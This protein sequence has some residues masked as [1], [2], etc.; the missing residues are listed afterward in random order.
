MNFFSE[1]KDTQPRRM[2]DTSRADVNGFGIDVNVS[3]KRM[4][5]V[6][7]TQKG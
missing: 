5:D 3:S 4:R 1:K 7:C 6:R 2:T